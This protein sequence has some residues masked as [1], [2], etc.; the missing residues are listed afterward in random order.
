MAAI[1]CLLLAAAAGASPH[2]ARRAG[3]QQPPLTFRASV[4]VLLIDVQVVP[5][6]PAQL[7]S[8]DVFRALGPDDFQIRVSGGDRPT[9]S[10][11][12]LHFDTGTVVHGP[13]SL[14]TGLRVPDCVFGFHRAA[15]QT[16]A[17]YLV[18]VPARDAD[19]ERV[20]GVHVAIANPGF[21]ARWWGWR[22][23]SHHDAAP[24][25]GH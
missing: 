10:L 7:S 24:P 8:P 21:L 11:T 23:P 20:K 13:L 12:L 2:G 6:I 3:A 17:H 1:A 22:T 9:V 25:A 16:T 15:D 19:R 5:A 14:L 18:G 4:D